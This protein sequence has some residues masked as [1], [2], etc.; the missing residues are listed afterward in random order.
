VEAA[1]RLAAGLP[2]RAQAGEDAQQRLRAVP[3]YRL[4]LG[5]RP[6]TGL[7]LALP[8]QR[9]GRGPDVLLEVPDV[10]DGDGADALG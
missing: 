8:I 6:A 3:P 2:P 4:D 7:G 9:F 5:R 1:D 10:E